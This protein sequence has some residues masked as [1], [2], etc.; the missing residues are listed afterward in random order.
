MEAG[1]V[2]CLNDFILLL[3]FNVRKEKSENLLA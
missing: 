2:L 3:I 1:D